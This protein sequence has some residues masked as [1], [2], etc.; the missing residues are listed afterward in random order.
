M[1]IMLRSMEEKHSFFLQ[2]AVSSLH[3]SFISEHTLRIYPSLPYTWK[4]FLLS[5]FQGNFLS[6]GKN[7]PVPSSFLQASLH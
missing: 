2:S 3:L 5:I 7:F 6:F 1:V 4:Q